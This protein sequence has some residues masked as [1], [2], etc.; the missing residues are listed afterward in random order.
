MPIAQINVGRLRGAKDGPE[1][2]EFMAALDAV[3]AIADAAPGFLW[4]LQDDAGNNTAMQPT[5]DGRFIVNISVWESVAAL[6]AFVY[7]TGHAD[8][9]RRR[10]EWFEP[11]SSAFMALWYVAEGHRPSVD[12]GLAR[13]WHLDRFGPTRHAFTFR[14]AAARPG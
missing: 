13:L 2:A 4:R 8:Y 9:V 3:N 14:D 10:R 6:Q 11:A 5:T 1:V 12:E 7:R